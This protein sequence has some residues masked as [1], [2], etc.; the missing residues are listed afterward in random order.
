MTG[1]TGMTD[2]KAV[3]EWAVASSGRGASALSI[4]QHLM[5]LKSDGYYPLDAS[6][7]WRCERLLD[8]VPEFR[9]MI[10]ELAAVNRYWAALAPR[11]D[12]IRTSA[13]IS[14]AIQSITRSIED[15]DPRLTRLGPGVTIRQGKP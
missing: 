4:A 2:Y 12:E 8:A 6:D 14:R 3:A 11:W 15:A 9:D 5:G 13:D 7:F 10:G 1:E